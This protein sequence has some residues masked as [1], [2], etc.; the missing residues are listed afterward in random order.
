VKKI[1]T[2]KSEASGIILN[3]EGHPN[4]WD[5]KP[6]FLLPIVDCSE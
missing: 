4:L 2:N 3:F 6:I 1:D 5:V